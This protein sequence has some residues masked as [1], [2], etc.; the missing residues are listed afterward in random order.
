MNEIKFI[1]AY[2]VDIPEDEYNLYVASSATAA[3]EM[4]TLALV[5]IEVMHATRDFSLLLFKQ[6]HT[7]FSPYDETYYDAKSLKEL[8]CSKPIA[9]SFRMAFYLH[10]F[11][12]DQS[13]E[14]PWGEIRCGKMQPVPKHLQNKKY[15]YWR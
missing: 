14:T 15:I 4:A 10:H 1:G 13:L 6:P 9:E 11:D 5:E 7:E 2:A 8:G 12:E 3:T